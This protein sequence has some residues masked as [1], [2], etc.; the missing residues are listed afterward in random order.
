M[1][2]G[3]SACLGF[4]NCRYDGKGFTFDKD[5]ASKF[6][7]KELNTN[8][9]IEFI[10]VCAEVEGGL[11]TPRIPSEIQNGD[12]KDVWEGKAKVVNKEGLD[13]TEYF[14]KGAQKVLD[15]AKEFGLRAFI[16]KEK[17]PS[18]GSLMIYN[19]KFNGETKSPAVG[20]TTALLEKN[21]IKVFSDTAINNFIP[22]CS[23][24]A[25]SSKKKY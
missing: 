16:L 2:I 8:E 4:D 7:Q 23:S 9:K 18:C 24:F 15:K 14:K 13:V 3:I 5:K 10:P 21:N 12:G 1:N 19:G 25:L 17:S 11:G 22:F 20:V 6:I